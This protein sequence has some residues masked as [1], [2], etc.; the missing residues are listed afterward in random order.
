MISLKIINFNHMKLI[1]LF[2]RLCLVFVVVLVINSCDS[3]S[4][5]GVHKNITG[6]AGELVVVISDESWEGDPGK[7]IRKHLARPN[8]ALPQDE[9]VF[10]LIKVPHEGFKNIFKTTRNIIQAR[11]S[12]YVDSTGVFYKDDV[13][14]HP[15]A[16]VI[17]Q[18]K[19]EKQFTEI[20]EAE[21]NDII[22]YFLDAEMERL[23][24]NYNK[25]YERAIFNALSEDFG[26]TMK[27]PPGFQIA[28][29]KDDFIWLRFES[30]R[31]SQGIVI[32]TFP[33]KSTETFTPEYLIN[34]RDSVLKAEIPGP[35]EGSYMATERRIEPVF[36]IRTHNGNYAT[37]MRG[38]WRLINDFMGGPYISLAVLDMAN[39]RVIVTFGYV[40]APNSDKRDYIRQV[41][42]MIYSLKLNNQAANDKLSKEIAIDEQ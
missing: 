22:S 31:I 13:W 38:L 41:E 35:T 42:A 33:Y 3:G 8:L 9:S 14:A 28:R 23:K 39:Q 34:I 19:N 18:A 15:Q 25:Y 10:D 16:T 4:S 2:L 5:G 21:S 17:L 26:I 6:K 12:P 37:E 11:I 24:M 36:S 29:Q 30:P 20:F 32:Y 27:V 7:V 40:Y 1:K